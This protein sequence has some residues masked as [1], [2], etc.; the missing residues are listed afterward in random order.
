MNTADRSIGR[1]DYAIRRRFVFHSIKS[2]LE[3]IK[4]EK[5]KKLFR[6]VKDLISDN[7]SADFHVEDIMV[8]HSYFLPQNRSLQ[9]RFEWEIK[10]LLMEYLK[11]GIL[12][13]NGVKES[14][15][16]LLND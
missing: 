5:S 14:I 6:K 15:Q 7:I 2:D 9:H 13:G 16:E 8:G 3:V 1:V 10:P 12:V 11:D 4:D